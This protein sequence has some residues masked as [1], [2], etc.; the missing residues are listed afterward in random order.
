MRV[1]HFTVGGDFYTK[2]IV[3][4]DN[5]KFGLRRKEEHQD[6]LLN[7]NSDNEDDV[8]NG[9]VSYKPMGDSEFWLN[10]ENG[11]RLSVEQVRVKRNPQKTIRIDPPIP[12]AEEIAH[13]EEMLKVYEAAKAKAI[14]KKQAIPNIDDFNI[15]KTPKPRW[16][17]RPLNFVDELFT[18]EVLE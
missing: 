11:T 17:T 14:N 6:E 10:F 5:F 13:K 8:D 18:E 4:K 7:D 16:E 2:A 15:P 9:L 1:D 3:I 12:T